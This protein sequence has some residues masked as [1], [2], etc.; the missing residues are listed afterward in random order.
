MVNFISLNG[1]L[2]MILGGRPVDVNKEDKHYPEI[3]DALKSNASEDDILRILN[4][5][6]QRMQDYMKLS[7][8][9]VI[10]SGAISFQGE[11]ID[12][13]LN[14][15]ILRMME[16]GFDIS[17]MIKFLKNLMQN[18]SHRVIHHL[19]RFMEF[20]KIPITDDGC[21]LVYKA[22]KADF[23]DIYTGT[24]DNSIG[25]IPKVPRRLVNDDPRETCSYGLHV[26]SFGYLPYFSHANGHVLVCKV[27]PQNVVAIPYDYNNTKMRV[28]EYEVVS[29]YKDYY[30]I[31]SDILASTSVSDADGDLEP[32][33]CVTVKYHSGEFED[34]RTYTIEE[35]KAVMAN[36]IEQEEEDIVRIELW[37]KTTNTM[38]D[39]W[40]D[41]DSQAFSTTD[42][43]NFTIVEE[44]DDGSHSVVG[45]P[46]KSLI[47]ALEEAISMPRNI[48]DNSRTIHILGP[49]G[50]IEKTLSN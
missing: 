17:P 25:Q 40:Q 14:A 10:E 37:N 47:S 50:S 20:G 23:T 1:T 49:T 15:H 36:S 32:T 7:D 42:A 34:H 24:F 6:A 29:E 5:E 2:H 21:F 33:F 39:F 26:C 11:P 9:I 18:P 31:F 4:A 28:C 30:T 45:M 27:N 43:G 8:D 16:E 48:G 44:L 41:N 13:V 22:V 38:L 12:T 19:Y 46:H 3:N 35:A